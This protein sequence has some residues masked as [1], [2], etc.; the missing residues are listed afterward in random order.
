MYGYDIFIDENL[1]PWL[2]EINAN[3]SLSANT[4]LDAET[5]IKMLDDLLI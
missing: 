4:E 2:I 3:A 5:K 1:R